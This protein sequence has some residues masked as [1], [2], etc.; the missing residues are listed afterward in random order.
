MVL[1]HRNIE[2][3]QVIDGELVVVEMGLQGGDELNLIEPGAN[4]GWPL[5]SYGR[6]Y[7][8]FGGAPIGTGMAKMDGTVQP[9]YFWDPVIAPN[10]FIIYEGDMFPEWQGDML[11]T[12]L[13]AGGLV[14]LSFGEDGLVDEEERVLPD[15][16]RTRD[17]EIGDDGALLVVTDQED[18]G[19]RQGSCRLHSFSRCVLGW[20]GHGAAA[21]SFMGE[22]VGSPMA[23][24]PGIG[25][26]GVKPDRADGLPVAG[27][28]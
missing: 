14:R 2:G 3:A 17:V 10:D 11:I 20:A 24:A 15:L 28:T 16:K 5:V 1:R 26:L 4:Y 22:R 21:A 6:R 19:V 13:V 25:S 27:L 7:E 18:G 12:A 8:R 23:S 9:L